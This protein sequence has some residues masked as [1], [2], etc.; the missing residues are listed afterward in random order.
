MEFNPEPAGRAVEQRGRRIPVSFTARAIPSI[1]ICGYTYRLLKSLYMD[2]NN[3][4]KE[5]EFLN[6]IMFLPPL[7]NKPLRGM[8]YQC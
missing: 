6:S 7:D 3:R 2:H 8:Y 1:K 4:E 5:G